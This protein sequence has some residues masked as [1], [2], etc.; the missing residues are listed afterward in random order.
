MGE[1]PVFYFDL[2]SPYSYLAAFRLAR[3]LPAAPVW[4]PVWMAPILAAAGREWRRPAEEVRERQAGIE[5]RAAGYGMPP[6]RWPEPYL[7]GRR[8]GV[9]APPINALAVMRLATYAHDAGV[10][11]AFARRAYHLAFGEGHDIT[12]VD[13]RVIETAVA[14]GLDEGA[15]RAAPA[16][17]DVKQ[18]LRE[19]TDA[20]VARGVKGLPT[21][22]VGDA[23]FWGDDRLEDAA[24]ALSGASA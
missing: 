14:C 16:D 22:A 1:A 9:E 8:L 2:A 23:L 5:R 13:E 18:A 12:T 4:Q 24:A 6:W 20:V 17:P 10:G 3:I 19:A 15:A 11:E 7:A 21:V